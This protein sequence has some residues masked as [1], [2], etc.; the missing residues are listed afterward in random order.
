MRCALRQ[1]RALDPT[2]TRLPTVKVA[3]VVATVRRAVARRGMGKRTA[4]VEMA[5]LTEIVRRRRLIATRRTA[6]TTIIVL[7]RAAAPTANPPRML[8]AR[9]FG[10]VAST[11]SSADPSTQPWPA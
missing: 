5:V 6:T 8:H 11:P 1:V 9:R 7:D 3:V 2:A 10:A 4:V